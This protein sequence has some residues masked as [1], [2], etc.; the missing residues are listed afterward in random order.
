MARKDCNY[1]P[2]CEI[3][4][5]SVLHL[6]YKQGNRYP[7]TCSSACK[8]LLISAAIKPTLVL[9][10]AKAVRAR[11]KILPSGETIAQ[12]ASRKANETMEKNGT[13]MI[14][15]EKR[16]SKIQFGPAFGQKVREGM[17]KVG[18]DGLTA[19]ERGARAARE[20]LIEKG[21]FVDPEKQSEWYRY[22][23]K[24]RYLTSKQPLH[25][26]ENIEK[27]G[28]VDQG[29]WHLDHIVSVR[30]GFERGTPPEEIAHI[31]NLQM[32]PAIDNIRKGPR[33]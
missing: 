13:R 23:R 9:R 30:T 22:S 18:N 11:K 20:T 16:K 3:C 29:G 4:N 7:R 19:A 21:I 28:P 14:A 1:Q 24:V 12:S 17:M 10:A 6:K 27:R 5:K 31:S 2:V 33:R 8:G 15:A 26:L 32:L 25:L